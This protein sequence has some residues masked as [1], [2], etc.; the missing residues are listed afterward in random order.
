MTRAGTDLEPEDGRR[1][2]VHPAR[3]PRLDQRARPAREV[4][5]RGSFISTTSCTSPAFFTS[6]EALRF[7]V[8][9]W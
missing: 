1:L 3:D 6:P 4:V 2:G 9:M 7:L 5:E 8:N